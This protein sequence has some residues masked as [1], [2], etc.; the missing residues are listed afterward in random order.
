MKE[1]CWTGESLEVGGGVGWGGVGGGR[2]KFPHSNPLSE[3]ACMT[4]FLC[5]FNKILW[6]QCLP[7][8]LVCTP[9]VF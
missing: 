2:R 4:I 8:S 9:H 5:S 6:H 7:L 3:A 1:G